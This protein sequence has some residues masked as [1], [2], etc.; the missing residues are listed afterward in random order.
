MG[1]CEKYTPYP[2]PISSRISEG[3]L[4]GAISSGPGWPNGDKTDTD[5]LDFLEGFLVGLFCCGT[6]GEQ[7]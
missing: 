2:E 3:H 5:R 1:L 7:P 4:C 6:E